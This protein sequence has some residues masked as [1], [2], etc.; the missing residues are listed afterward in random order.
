MTAPLISLMNNENEIVYVALKNMQIICQKRP[1]I[2]E[3]EIKPFFCKFND[4]IY[5]KLEKLELM[6]L[7]ASVDNYQQILNE[8]REY[9]NEVDVEFVKK[10]IRAISRIA[11][12]NEKAAD[13]SVA[14]L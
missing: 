7:L 5:V 1:I 2:L 13:R 3:K 10:T 9:T 4:P 8:F 12:K 6:V 11:I 14:V